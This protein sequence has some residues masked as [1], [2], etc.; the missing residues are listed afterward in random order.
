[1]DALK[2]TLTVYE[3]KLLVKCQQKLH[4]I[5]FF[6]VFIVIIESGM[7]IYLFSNMCKKSR[8]KLFK[9]MSKSCVIW[10]K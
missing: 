9:F 4:H 10:P 2:Q 6:V 7:K 3:L 8:S 5:I 1:M